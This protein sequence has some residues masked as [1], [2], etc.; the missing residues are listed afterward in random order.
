MLKPVL[1]VQH[2]SVILKATY[3]HPEVHSPFQSIFF[4]IRQEET[5]ARK[6]TSVDHKR[7]DSVKMEAR[8]SQAMEKHEQDDIKRSWTGKLKCRVLQLFHLCT[9]E[10]RGC[11]YG[12]H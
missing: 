11:G 2:L 5:A 3:Q 4:F 1:F 7:T 8:G 10:I 9:W 12:E 6:L